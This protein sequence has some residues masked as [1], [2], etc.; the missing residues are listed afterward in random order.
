[1]VVCLI[2]AGLVWTVGFDDV[3]VVG[4]TT[5]FDVVVDLTLTL[6]VDVIDFG[7]VGVEAGPAGAAVFSKQVQALDKRE[8]G[9]PAKLLGTGWLGDLRKLGQKETASL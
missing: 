3:D 9:H 2:V 4:T 1:M 6:D 8:A 5:G 7:V